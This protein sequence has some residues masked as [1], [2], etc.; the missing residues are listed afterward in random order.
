MTRRV[1]LAH[2]SVL[3][4]A[5]VNDVDNAVDDAGNTAV[6]AVDDGAVEADDNSIQDSKG[7]NFRRVNIQ[8]CS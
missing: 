8:M 7:D 4:I 3:I 5:A 2:V 1:L 6:N